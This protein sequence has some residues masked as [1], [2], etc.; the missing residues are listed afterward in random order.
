MIAKKDRQEI[1]DL[2]VQ[3]FK[4]KDLKVISGLNPCIIE[5]AGTRI[6][7]YIKNLTPAQLSNKNPDIC[8]CQLPSRQI[9]DDFKT[10]PDLFLFLGYDASNDVYATWNPYWTKQ[11]LNIGV[12]IS[13]Y[14]RYSIQKE[15]STSSKIIQYDL[16][17][18]GI[19]V[20]MPR[21]LLTE[22]IDHLSTYFDRETK[23]IAIGS[24]LRTERSHKNNLEK[25]PYSIFTNTDNI[26]SFKDYLNQLPLAESTK[27]K[28][29][30]CVHLVFRRNFHNKYKNIFL[31]Y[32]KLSEYVI[33]ID[34]LCDTEE[35]ALL[36]RRGKH[37]RY[38]YVSAGLKCYL[39]SLS[40]PLTQTSENE[41]SSIDRLAKL[42]PLDILKEI[43]DLMCKS[44]PQEMEAMQLLYDTVGDTYNQSMTLSDWVQLLRDADW[45]KIKR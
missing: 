36:D 15:V 25:D 45:T 4:E 22:Y 30:S 37:G 43:A 8:R 10:S 9:F 2:F 6:N 7:V 13:M 3:A 31:K 12:N 26:H 39:K 42:C 17:H 21:L 44:E 16:H 33:A 20:V 11:R 23:Y 27:N 1:F 14:S 5:Y 40:S 34:E 28:Y 19:V 35:I 38:G 24:S 41:N 29:L 18:K 32:K